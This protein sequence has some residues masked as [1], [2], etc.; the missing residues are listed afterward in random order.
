MSLESFKHFAS[1]EQ[2]YE[3]QSNHGLR[4]GVPI[5][6]IPN[7]LMVH[8]SVSTN[9]L[10]TT[11]VVTSICFDASTIKKV[12]IQ[13]PNIIS[14]K[15]GVC[16]TSL[17]ISVESSFLINYSDFT[18]ESSVSAT[19]VQKL[20]AYRNGDSQMFVFQLNLINITEGDYNAT[21]RLS[22]AAT[23]NFPNETFLIFPIQC[24]EFSLNQFSIVS[25]GVPTYDEYNGIVQTLQFNFD[26]FFYSTFSDFFYDIGCNTNPTFLCRIRRWVNRDINS[27]F[28]ILTMIQN[29][30][31]EDDTINVQITLATANS[32]FNIT[33]PNLYPH[34]SRTSVLQ[35]FQTY[36]AP[37][38]SYIQSQ[39]LETLPAYFFMSFT[40]FNSRLY[41]NLRTL[42]VFNN[43]TLTIYTGFLSIQST[44]PTLPIY[45][46]DNVSSILNDTYIYSFTQFALAPGIAFNS[47]GWILDSTTNTSFMTFNYSSTYLFNFQSSIK[48]DTNTLSF[49]NWSP[50]SII[51]GKYTYQLE[52]PFIRSTTS[53]TSFFGSLDLRSGTTTSIVTKP[54]NQNPQLYAMDL[55]DFKIVSVFTILVRIKI[56]SNCPITNINLL[57]KIITTS[58]LIDG[59][60]YNGTYEMEIFPFSLKEF[61]V[62][63]FNTNYKGITF[64]SALPYNKRG[65]ILP[66][67]P[68]YKNLL[69]WLITFILTNI[70]LDS[71]I[72]TNITYF[73]FIPNNID[74]TTSALDIKLYLNF[75]IPLENLTPSISFTSLSGPR[76]YWKGSYN[77]SL[78]LFEID[79]QLQRDMMMGSQQYQMDFNQMFSNNIQDYIL[80]SVIGQNATLNISKSNGGIY[81]SPQITD[82]N[83]LT[84]LNLTL[85]PNT[86]YTLGWDLNITDPY[87]FTNGS[88]YVLSNFDLLPYII[89][90]NSS[91]RISGGPTD[92]V[93]RIN[94]TINSNTLSQTFIMSNITLLSTIGKLQFPTPPLMLIYGT[95]KE[96]QLRLSVV[97][98][99][100][101]KD[102]E[103]PILSN[104]IIS[105]NVDVGSPI[106]T[107]EFNIMLFE[108]V[109]GSGVSIRH[110]PFIRLTSE[111]ANYMEINSIFKTTSGDGYYY[112]YGKAQLPYGF[113]LNNIFVSV[114]SIY[115]NFL[116]M[117]AYNSMDLKDIGL[118]YLI[119]RSFTFN[120][121]IIESSS[122]L[123]SRGG[124]LTIYGR[125]FGL[126]NNS[127][128][129]QIDYG[130]GFEDMNLNFHSGIILQF[131]NIKQITTDFVTVRV[132]RNNIFSNPFIIPVKKVS[133]PNPTS[134]PTSTA[135][136]KCPGT[137]ECNNNGNCINSICQC[138]LP[139][140]GPSC[141]SKIIIVPTPPAN[142]EPVTGTNITESGSLITT[143]IEIIGV[144]E[145]DDTMNIV[146]QFNIS[147]WNFTDLTTPTS[148]PKYFY[149]TQ[150]N[151]TTTFLN[152]SIEY[153]K[154]STNITFA[155]HNLYIPQSTIKFTMNLN[156]YK[157]DSP[158]NF[159]QILMKS[160][161]ETDSS[162]SC[163]SS[164][165]GVSGGSVEWIK[166]NIDDQ[167]LYGRFLSDAVID[168]TVTP[169]RNVIIDQDDTKSSNTNQ[170]RSAI[171]GI[172]IP[173]YLFSVDLDPDFSNLIDVDSN[174]EAS[175]IKKA[176][177]QN[178]NII[179]P[180]TGVCSTALGVLVES[181]FLI[182]YADFTIEH[183]ESTTIVQKLVAYRNGDSQMFVFQLNLINI[184]EGDYNATVRLSRASTP[185]FPNETFFI[186]P[187]QCKALFFNQFSIASQGVPTYDEN[188]GIVQAIQFNFDTSIYLTLSDFFYDIVC[189]TNGPFNC[190]ISKSLGR[191]LNSYTMTITINQNQV[192][193]DDTINV[194]ISFRSSNSSFNI[195][196]PNLYPHEPRTSVLQSFQTYPAPGG[197]YIQSQL[198]ES[199]PAYFFMS[200]T[201]FNSR[202]YGSFL[203]PRVFNN[204]TLTIYTGSLSIRNTISTLPIYIVDNVSSILNDT[205][206]YSFTRFELTSGI[207]YVSRY[208]NL[209]SGTNTS[210]ISFTFESTYLFNFQSTLRFGPNSLTLSN[211]CPY[212]SIN[213]KYIY[214][215]ET[216]F[217]QS[218]TSDISFLVSL[219]SNYQTTT[220]KVPY[221][222]YQNPQYLI[223]FKIVSV[224]TVLVRI[225]ILSNYAITTIHI[226]GKIITSNNLIDG[227]QY[228]G[229]Y[230]IEI[231]PL[232][233]KDYPVT[234]LSTNYET[235]YLFSALPYN[236]RGDILPD[237]PVYQNLCNFTSLSGPRIY[238]K[239]S[240]NTSL[241]LFE[242]DIQLQRDMMMGSQ[243]YQMDFNQMFSNNIQDYILQSV[244]GKNATLN[245]S[246]SS[247]GIYLSP[248]ITDINSLTA[249]NLTLLP[250]T[251]YTLGWDLNITDP[252]G[253]T[254]GS[255]YVLSNF[256]LLPYIILFNSSNRISGGPT[257]GVYR[258]N[259][260]INSNTL[261]QTFIMSNITLLSTIGKLQ[262]PTPPLMLIY[263]TPKEQQLRLSVVS[264]SDLKDI[265][266]PILSNLIISPNVD[267]GSPIRTVEFNIILFENITGSGVSIRHT[268]FIRLTSE[269][270][271]YMEINSIFKTTS[272]DGYYYFYGK[273]QLPYGFG[274]NNIF[275]SV[276]SIYDNFLN[277]R[278]YN[279]MDLKDI[280]LPYMVQRS[281]TFNTPIIESSSD[282]TSRGGS[283]TIYGRAFG[284]TNNS[285]LSQIDYGNGFED[286]NLNF[287]SGIILQFNNIKQITTDFV[288]V[289]VIR[290]NIFSN[291]F[292]IPVKKV[293]LPNPT[294]TPTS[295]APQKCPG[296][297]ECNNNGNCI[298]SICQCQ[299]PWY[300][301]SCSSKII[302]VPT[303]P[304]NP[305]P[306]T[307]TN[308]TESGSLITTSIEI[309]GVRELDDTMNIVK[310]F[311]ISNWN[312]TDLTTP[313]SNPKYFYSTQLKQTTTFLNVSIE[314]FKQ[315]T[316]IT[317]ANHN[318]YIPQS[319]IKFTMNLNSYKFDSPLNFLQILMKSSIET[320]S[321]D[322]CSS[323]G[324]GV[325]G[326]SV[327]W[328]K[329]NIDNQS[330]YGRFLSDAVIDYTVTPIRNV[331]IDQDDT[332][333]SNTNQI[334]S[335]I[336]GITIPNY[337]F[338]VDLDPDFSNLIDV[339][340]SDTSDLICSKKN[341]LS[342]GAIA[343]I[344]VGIVVFVSIVIAT[345]FFLAKKKK[346][347]KQEIR[348]KKK[349]EGM[350][351]KD[352]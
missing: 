257:D 320:D 152:V 274:F 38:G 164:G 120:T 316:N 174:T 195:T 21:V 104:L 176:V 156:S 142:P 8:V 84:A 191:Y 321:S 208:L 26:T 272:G 319:T 249:L 74:L 284:L 99:S 7:H 82:I 286:M 129:S 79:I 269:N 329:L 214:R 267:V 105:P 31:F 136:Q 131:N 32:S 322:S 220:S 153:F 242:I 262:F 160:S 234:I 117:R 23:S 58:N 114:Y 162:D 55:I 25:Q 52:T 185:N 190:G 206:N 349:L 278:A 138:Q 14:P 46:V 341:R 326:G 302:I 292:I 59:D 70:K 247:G 219:D 226:G 209:S 133:L 199:L 338:S 145:L 37:G 48:F 207:A 258:I 276:Y 40:N 298:N 295:T 128:L 232:V 98:T 312:F 246:K 96:Q 291:S 172:T 168:Y 89:L 69:L 218:T 275:V 33:V 290:N 159:L 256:D 134:T 212:G 324:V 108:N 307:G 248:Q 285:M 255:L 102:I 189:V 301:P 67:I 91:N 223:D 337:L 204:E 83:S 239:G 173:N 215:L 72:Y 277:M 2:R 335:A 216:P 211:W 85:L 333:S 309:I 107:V 281:F 293:S 27:Y 65:D 288:T 231:F 116:N 259:F 151:Q 22:R 250:N 343:G 93:Y 180:K 230:E 332:K 158:L 243:Q 318:L 253:F 140:Y 210:Y 18:I 20:D 137:P 194:Q 30:V 181:S 3:R 90:F 124:S 118:P 73:E 130:N 251:S 350:N 186:F 64:Y 266:A 147:N 236:K 150:L 68:V 157:F 203:R 44:I 87:G 331:I 28:L 240:Y 80:Q 60:Q 66:E 229:T 9:Q 135:P 296:T 154:Q 47:S 75:S 224:F 166:L 245:I 300:G 317:F 121:P 57:G 222:A 192:F 86:S 270:A 81:L 225:K 184:T 62:T 325:S 170:I 310:Q 346:F 205:Y 339:D 263:G 182:E 193:E 261:S 101:L 24:K 50:Y 146:K 200:F 213:G 179:S 273:A 100:D 110:T 29:Q 123:T 17:S 201:N 305:E 217:I 348:M 264:T 106:R 71:N 175:T 238:W 279:S 103:A 283:L 177:V 315:S 268:P 56:L 115:D 221:I 313:I 5:R 334:R 252:Y 112:F 254:N 237:Y 148:N 11:L 202:L 161:I 42:R 196:V 260:T 125:A 314:Y 34:G 126:T 53:D 342:N 122:D 183:S 169:I 4:K 36:P 299:L 78:Q 282:L 227:D 45:I 51:N 228:N 311:N 265:E 12:V 43:E 35:S 244:I 171:V 178:P 330:L 15:T 155:N 344:V 197:S 10:Y 198:L 143:S 323:S 139:W 187:I 308:I 165:V 109:T 141:S 49:S 119:Q 233:F 289:R 95:P 111:N 94:F 16:S 77:T 6:H 304:A 61:P 13:N 167:S 327:E 294:S 149:S 1:N 63:I 306:V 92:G 280:G 144:R 336:V 345:T 54:S 303:P 163:S 41:G 132:I 127:M 352:L 351:N 328:I 76:I 88:L 347:R 297:P 97:S 235:F 271:N 241:Q 39:L 287:H 188:N 19:I 340:S 113:G